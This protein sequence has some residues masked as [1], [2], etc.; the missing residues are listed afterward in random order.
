MPN[1]SYQERTDL[2]K[3]Q[4]QWNKPGG[5]HSREEW[6]AAIVRTATAAEIA[7]SF[8]IGNYAV[9][10]WVVLHLR[11]MVRYHSKASVKT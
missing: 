11:W 2:Q 9:G 7:A 1:K 3:I 4:S 8:A 6:S 5:L 10:Q